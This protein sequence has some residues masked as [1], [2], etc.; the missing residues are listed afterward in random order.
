MKSKKYKSIL[1]FLGFTISLSLVVGFSGCNFMDNETGKMKEALNGRQAIVES[2]DQNSKVIDRVE[3]TS[4]SIKRDTKFDET[5]DEGNKIKNSPVINITVGGKEMIHVG[6]S[7]ILYETGLIDVF[8]EYAKTV[9]ID[10]TDRSTPF[11]NRMVSSMTNLT[12]GKK[13][14]IL[15]RSQSG[16]PLATFVGNNISYFSTDVPNSTGILID[17]KYLFIYRSDYTIYDLDLLK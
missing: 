17:G 15:I 12:S 5:D 14:A 16:K 9:N 3:G 1:I 2:F 7:L 8:N 10:N 11:I 6:S 13:R 4:I